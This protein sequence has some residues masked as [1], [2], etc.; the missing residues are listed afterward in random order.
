MELSLA[1]FNGKGEV[2]FMGETRS[3]NVSVTKARRHLAV[4]CDSETVKSEFLREY[5][6]YLEKE[7]AVKSASLYSCLSSCLSLRN[8][9]R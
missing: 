9:L 2:G 3:L 8:V 4:I 5:V 7:G 6:E 1:R